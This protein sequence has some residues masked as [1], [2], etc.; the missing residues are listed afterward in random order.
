MLLTE[1][2]YR[3]TWGVSGGGTYLAEM[4]CGPGPYVHNV[5]RDRQCHRPLQGSLWHEGEK[6]PRAEKVGEVQRVAFQL[7]AR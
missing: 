2:K 4:P 5:G 1:G 6:G 7:R 3:Q